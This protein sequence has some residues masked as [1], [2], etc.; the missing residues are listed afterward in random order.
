LGSDKPWTSPE[1]IEFAPRFYA[2]VNWGTKPNPKSNP[3]LILSLALA[4]LELFG[5]FFVNCFLRPQAS[6]LGLFGGV[7]EV[8]VTK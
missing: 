8:V 4:K 2:E 1:E 3:I 5:T 6:G 7:A